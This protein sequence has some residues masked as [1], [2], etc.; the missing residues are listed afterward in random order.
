MS[1]YCVNFNC[2]NL[3]NSSN[4]ICSVDEIILINLNSYIFLFYLQE[5]M[6]MWN[7]KREEIYER[8]IVKITWSSLP[9]ESTDEH[10]PETLKKKKVH[11]NKHIFMSRISQIY[12]NKIMLAKN[13]VRT[14]NIR[15]HN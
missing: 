14:K 7:K 1:C 6:R 15:F 10:F 3:C 13:K 2:S 12:D 4:H 11:C 5:C 9:T 8:K